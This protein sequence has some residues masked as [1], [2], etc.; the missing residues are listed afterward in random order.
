MKTWICLLFTSITLSA[1]TIDKIKK[2]EDDIRQE[3]IKISRQLGVTCTECHSTKNFKSTE[4]PSYKV[5][6]T[7]L[8]MTALLKRNGLSGKNGEPEA[9]CFTCHRGQLKFEHQEKLNDHTRLEPP[10]KLPPL[11]EEVIDDKA[12]SN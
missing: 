9:T 2:S 5:S 7:H 3:M 11:K 1:Q 4:K 10:K 6:L 8:K 12:E